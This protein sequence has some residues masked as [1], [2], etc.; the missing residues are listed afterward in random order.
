MCLTP[1]IQYIC[2]AL[3]TDAKMSFVC[4]IDPVST[5]FERL[6]VSIIRG[7]LMHY[8]NTRLKRA[9]LNLPGQDKHITNGQFLRFAVEWFHLN[10]KTTQMVIY[11][12][13]GIK[14]NRA[15]LILA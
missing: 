13:L 14:D 6:A 1:R 8:S 7:S 15:Q 3:K 10:E 5:V 2:Q 9:G 12:Y 4:G 11:T